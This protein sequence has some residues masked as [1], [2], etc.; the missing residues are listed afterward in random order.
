MCVLGGEF[1]I[2]KKN[3]KSCVVVLYCTVFVCEEKLCCKIEK[4]KQKKKMKKNAG[5]A[6]SP[7]GGPGKQQTLKR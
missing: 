6:Q 7:L 1:K 4:K 5:E 2:Q 3:L